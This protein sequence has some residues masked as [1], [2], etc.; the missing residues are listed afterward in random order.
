MSDST[1]GV[2]THIII[3]F[4]YFSVSIGHTTGSPIADTTIGTITIDRMPNVLKSLNTTTES[5]LPRGIT[6]YNVHDFLYNYRYMFIECLKTK[7][8]ILI[9]IFTLGNASITIVIIVTSGVVVIFFTML[10]IWC[11]IRYVLIVQ[12]RVPQTGP[13]FLFQYDK[14]C[15]YCC[16]NLCK[17][18]MMYFIKVIFMKI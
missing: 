9:V 13:I 14:T 8:N 4:N 16:N 12:C 1:H 11:F 18:I 17:S 5:C 10:I 2:R 6:R 15:L 3:Y 7:E